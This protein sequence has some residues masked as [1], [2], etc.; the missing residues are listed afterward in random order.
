MTS[1]NPTV[2]TRTTPDRPRRRDIVITALLALV[3][4]LVL[5]VGGV[6]AP[7][8]W[9][10]ASLAFSALA[11]IYFLT[12]VT[13]AAPK[14]SAQITRPVV[15]SELETAS[16]MLE[17]IAVPVLLIGPGGRIERANPAARAFLALGAEGGLLS[18]S[19]RQ[20]RVL[21]AVSAALRGERG[22]VVEYA[23]LAPIESHVRA[24]VEPLRMPVA[25]PMPWRAMLVL[26]DETSSKRAERMRADFLANASHELRTPLASLSGFIDTLRGP[27]RDDEE[28]RD[29]FL[30]IMREQTDR[31]R[32]LIDD[33]LSLSRVEMNEHLPPSGEADLGA[34]V[35]D[36]VDSLRPMAD[37][38]SISFE[39]SLPEAPAKVTGDR[40]QVYEVVEN[41]VE[42]AIK[43]S[44]EGAVV[45]IEALDNCAR[46]VAEH[47]PE[48]LAP[49][50]ARLLLAG[51]PF[52]PR[53]RYGVLRVRDNGAGIDR[54]Y[55]PRLSER[56]YRVDG[57]KSGPTAGT[58]LGLAI[59]KHIITRHRGGFSVESATGVGSAFSVFL[60][61]PAEAVAAASAPSPATEATAL[62]AE[63]E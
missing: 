58:G 16:A 1:E 35:R 42:N 39:L 52:D 22:T 17:K 62:E 4:L 61:K 12:A 24:F 23:S 26:A 49:Q 25:G 40:D 3:V 30:T 38:R 20:P 45:T 6:L 11:F 44:P 18:T 55:L 2:R 54:R 29:R 19:L 36:V 33:L 27:A 37:A 46:D 32:R 51:P 28:A 63:T 13:R 59:V 50:S 60:P 57:Q 41:L 34:I 48:R 9:L 8:A 47:T 56:F 43:Y 7:G 21:E 15:S 5:L 10:A 53:Q 31:M 14:P